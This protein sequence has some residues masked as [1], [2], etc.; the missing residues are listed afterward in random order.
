MMN[1]TDDEL[2]LLLQKVA[3]RIRNN[4][5]DENITDSQLTVLFQLDQHGER[6]PSQLAAYERLTPPSMNRTLNGLET[7]GLI[8]RTR[9]TDDGRRVIVTLTPEGGALLAETRRL[10]TAWFSQ[11]LAG[12]GREERAALE[13]AASVLRKLAES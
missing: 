3:R 12:L 10:R 1:V 4:R 6:T 11:Q 9:S 7:A 2:R 5:G 8:E 13:A